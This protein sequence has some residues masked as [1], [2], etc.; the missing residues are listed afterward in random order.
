MLSV[1]KPVH[2]SL[3]AGVVVKAPRYKTAVAGSIPDG[4]TG[5]FQ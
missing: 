5:I 3:H 2:T 4:V 1:L